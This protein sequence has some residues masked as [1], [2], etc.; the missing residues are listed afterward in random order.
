[1]DA[2][3]AVGLHVKLWVCIWIYTYVAVWGVSFSSSSRSSTKLRIYLRD[4]HICQYLSQAS[5]KLNTIRFFTIIWKFA[6]G[7]KFVGACQILH[8]LKFSTYWTLV[9][10]AQKANGW[11]PS[12]CEQLWLA[13]CRYLILA[14]AALPNRH[15]SILTSSLPRQQTWLPCVPRY[16]IGSMSDMATSQSPGCD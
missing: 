1:M 14:S 8:F 7:K 13:R 9:A 2:D 12:K 3:R 15:G 11:R 16:L 6:R 10:S 5:L 4:C